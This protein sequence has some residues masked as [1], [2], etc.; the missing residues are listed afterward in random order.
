[1]IVNNE[2]QYFSNILKKVNYF[3]NFNGMI[4]IVTFQSIEDKIVKEFFKIL[5]YENIFVLVFKRII[6]ASHLEI[7]LNISSRSSKLRVIKKIHY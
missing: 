4:V 2:M 3:L 5:N 7:K 6:V 1:M